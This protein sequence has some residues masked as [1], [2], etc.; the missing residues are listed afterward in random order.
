MAH[1]VC[2]QLQEMQKC[3]DE[4]D[5]SM[6]QEVIT[7]MDPTVSYSLLYGGI[8]IFKKSQLTCDFFLGGQTSY[9]AVH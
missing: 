4:K 6:L 5:I 2:L 8:F 3:F 7:K 9:E 1:I